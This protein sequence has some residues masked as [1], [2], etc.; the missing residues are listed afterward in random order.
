M[1]H[2]TGDIGTVLIKGQQERG[3]HCLE[4]G[5]G[6]ARSRTFSQELNLSLVNTYVLDEISQFFGQEQWI[7]GWG[8][9]SEVHVCLKEEY[10]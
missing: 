9:S 8:G 1:V 3:G 5:G 7:M 2:R 4:S 10:S 6:A